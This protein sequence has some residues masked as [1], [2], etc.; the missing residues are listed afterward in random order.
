ETGEGLMRFKNGAIG[1]LAA[2]WDDVANPLQYL[3]SGTEGHAA[4]ISG[5]IHFTTKKEPKFDGSTPVRQGELPAAKPAGFDA[6]LDAITG[7]EATLVGAREA[8]YRSSVM[9]AMYAGAKDGKWVAPK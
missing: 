6:F 2:S 5:Q 4:V 9:E 7:K 8:A 3:I 1:T